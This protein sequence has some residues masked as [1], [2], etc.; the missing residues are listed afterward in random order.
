MLTIVPMENIFSVK[1][2]EN[3]ERC[4]VGLKGGQIENHPW[5]FDWRHDLALTFDLHQ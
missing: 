3:G 5:A 1:Y 2:L 4:D